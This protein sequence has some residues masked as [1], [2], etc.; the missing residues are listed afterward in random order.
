VL[1]FTCLWNLVI[2]YF[3]RAARFRFREGYFEK[4]QCEVKLI[5]LKGPV[6]VSVHDG[7]QVLGIAINVAVV[8]MHMFAA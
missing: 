3:G 6:A 8:E 5:A 7:A 4:C 2:E 1:R